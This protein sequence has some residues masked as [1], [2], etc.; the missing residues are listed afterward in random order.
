MLRLGAADPASWPRVDPM[1]PSPERWLVLLVLFVARTAIAYQFQTVASVGS[2]LVETLH[3]D[4]AT[5][6]TL[7]G[8]YMLPGVFLALPGGALGQRFGAK[9]VAL[10]GL[11]LMG[12]GGALMA[13]ESFP[14]VVAGRLV[15]GAGA[16]LL[17]VLVTKMTADWFTG[18]EA[19]TA[20]AILVSSW[21]LGLA[22][23]LVTFPPLAAVSSWSGVMV[24]AACVAL[25]CLAPVGFVYREP[26]GL[27]SAAAPTLRIRLARREWVLVLLAGAI[28]GTYNVGYIVL[29]SFLPGVFVTRGYSLVEASR[30][31]SFLG[32]ALIVSV[33]LGGY[34]ASR[35]HWP[36]LLMVGGIGVVATAMLA[37]P[38]GDTPLIA[39]TAI[40]LTI[41][42]P[43]GLIM[44]LPG[45][46][47]QPENRAAGMGIFFTCFY[48]L[49][50][51]LPPF[52]GMA[53]DL[54]GAS[55]AALFAAG[56]MFVAIFA[57][58]AFRLVQRSRDA[59]AAAVD[60]A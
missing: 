34:V 50:A 27:R 6:G 32:W 55:A 11:A 37:L 2:Y 39:F 41:G 53:R 7:I 25:A 49:M 35:L 24:A 18:R 16:V 46:A 59:P 4:F 28:W 26:S 58:L 1:H 5:V 14:L 54:A 36:N 30:M 51:L 17:N 21:P 40:V 22:L 3:V 20:M 60:A 52:A 33:P 29:I 57:V 9:H 45:E 31:V 23:G 13:V 42:I 47:L 43:A 19:V 15:S 44:A 12:A 38:F 10:A 56:M 8:L 48:G